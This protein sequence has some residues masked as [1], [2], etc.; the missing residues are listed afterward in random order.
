VDNFVDNSPLTAGEASIYAGFNRL[1]KTEAQ[2]KTFLIN[3]L[4]IVEFRN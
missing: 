3:D 2:I 1:P 4:Q